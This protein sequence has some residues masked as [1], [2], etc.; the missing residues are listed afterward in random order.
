LTLKEWVTELWDRLLQKHDENV[1]AHS[2][3][4]NGVDMKIKDLE[5]RTETNE[6]RISTNT[7]RIAR[8]NRSILDL[9]EAE[10]NTISLPSRRRGRGPGR[11]RGQKL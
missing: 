1:D 4:M 2:T 8:Q 7:G 3:R 9:Y 6:E 11:K 5:R 10:R